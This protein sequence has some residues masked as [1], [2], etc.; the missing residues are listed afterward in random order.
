[1]QAVIVGVGQGRVLA[2]VPVVR[3]RTASVVI[4]RRQTGRRIPIDGDDEMQ[5]AQMLVAN[6]QGASLTELPFDLE[7]ALLRVGVLYV[8][9]HGREVSQDA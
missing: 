3:I 9:I 2:I 5:S 6:A 8:P 7:A 1:M 4:P